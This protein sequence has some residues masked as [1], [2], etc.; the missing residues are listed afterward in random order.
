MRAAL[1]G[2]IAAGKTTAMEVFKS[3]GAKVFYADAIARD[4]LESDRNVIAAVNDYF[5]DE[6]VAGEGSAFDIPKLSNVVFSSAENVAFMNK[7]IH[8]LV[9]KEIEQIFKAVEAEDIVVIEI[10]L[11]FESQMQDMFD[12]T[13][14][15]S[16][17]VVSRIERSL[18]RNNQTSEQDVKDR[19]A[20][21]ITDE[22]KKKLADYVIVNNGTIDD[23][24][25]NIKDIWVKLK[26]KGDNNARRK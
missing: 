14:A 16:A 7:L 1:T 6:N 18:R 11:L 8:P 26:I 25:Q 23:M 12:C 22:E 19:M 17:T 15:I 13:I 24:K 4:I 3:L 21:Q 5:G 2:G 20:F 10:P 9:R